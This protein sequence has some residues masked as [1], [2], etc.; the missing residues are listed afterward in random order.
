MATFTG[1]RDSSIPLLPRVG[2]SS[3]SPFTAET[4]SS[5]GVCSAVPCVFCVSSQG[6]VLYPPLLLTQPN[7]NNVAVKSNKKFVFF[8]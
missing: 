8:L 6:V 5:L 7:R 2:A 1:A 3:A 4:D